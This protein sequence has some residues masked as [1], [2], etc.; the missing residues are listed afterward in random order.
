[1]TAMLASLR[2][3]GS[4]SATKARAPMFCRP[5]EF[6][7]PAAVSKTRGGGLPG[8][9]SRERPLTTKPPS[10]SSATMSS[11]STPYPKVPLAAMIGFLKLMPAKR[12]VRSGA[13]AL[14]RASAQGKR[15]KEKGKRNAHCRQ[16][17][18]RFLFPFSFFLLPSSFGAPGAA[19][20]QRLGKH[21]SRGAGRAIDAEERGERGGQVARLACAAIGAGAKR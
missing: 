17:Q 5:M 21:T 7:M 15:K 20:D 11:N 9:G 16:V 4:F 2:R 19:R 14:M 6:S 8:M 1:M 18:A 3:C 12:M 13:E 10:F